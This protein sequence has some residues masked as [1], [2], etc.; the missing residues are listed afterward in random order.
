MRYLRTF[1]VPLLAMLALA[2]S[3]HAALRAPSLEAPS[4]TASVEAAP[5]FT[6]HQVTG[7]ATY[8]FQIAADKQF[9]SVAYSAKTKNTAATLKETLIDG[10]YYWRVRGISA[11][12]KAG[13]WSTVRT[14]EKKWA[15]VPQLQAP[16]DDF[17]AIWPSA[18]LVL[19]WSTV[20]HATSYIVVV[21]TDPS[22]AQPVLGTTTTPQ[23][24]QGTVLA[25][26]GTLNAGTYYWQ[27]TP[28]D[29]DGHK[30]TP[31]AVGRFSWGWPS[32]LSVQAVD[33]NAAAE[34]FD[35][36]LT[37]SAVAGAAHY[38][39]E[40]NTTPDFA[41][42][43]TF[44]KST[45]TGT[46]VA[47]T[48]PVPNNT[49]FFRVRA[50]DPDGRAGSYVS[51]SFRKEFDDTT[52]ASPPRETVPGLTLRD[53]VTDAALAV[54]ATTS[55]PTLSWNPVPGAAEYEVQVAP[56]D[57][58]VCDWIHK[59]ALNDHGY[60]RNPFTGLRAVAGAGNPGAGDWPLAS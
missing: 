33:L 18:P 41:P 30:G 9:G 39:V 44:F 49:Y 20:A 16:T 60:T 22:L 42:G 45:V 11:T 2:P 7:A 43:S 4:A 12:P 53:G 19:T 52:G 13:R 5:T 36:L 58:A 48:V 31:S 10:T 21:A 56:R 8:E 57:G 25:F 47:P 23:K 14:L 51:G 55:S 54:G 46:S 40:V 32:G 29:A 3:A 35:P 38:D 59:V 34:V 37:W 28:V 50:V 24:T 27:I 26:P 6:W 1:A 17:G 15:T